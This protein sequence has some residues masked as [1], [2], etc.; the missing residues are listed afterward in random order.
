MLEVREREVSEGACVKVGVIR[1]HSK[2]T[3]LG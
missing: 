3:R 1:P 2:K